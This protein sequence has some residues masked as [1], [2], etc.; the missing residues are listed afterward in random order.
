MSRLC[1]GIPSRPPAFYEP[2]R[3]SAQSSAWW[4]RPKRCERPDPSGVAKEKRHRLQVHSHG[5]VCLTSSTAFSSSLGGWIPTLTCDT[6]AMLSC[7]GPTGAVGNLASA[8]S[9]G[10]RE[11]GRLMV[12]EPPKGR[13]GVESDKANRS[14]G[15]SDSQTMVDL[16][17]LPEVFLWLYW[18]SCATCDRP[19]RPTQ[20]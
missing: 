19:L 2:S 15:G 14:T 5:H 8:T 3:G 12:W 9:C 18:T 16:S 20:N 4:D 10:A 7:L 17:G 13:E 1:G 11:P 6:G